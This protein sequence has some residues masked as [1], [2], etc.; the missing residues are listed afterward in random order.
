[1]TLGRHPRR[2]LLRRI[3]LV[4]G[5]L[6][7]LAVLIDLSLDKIRDTTRAS[8][9]PAAALAPRTQSAAPAEGKPSGSRGS[10]L[11]TRKREMARFRF[12][13]ERGVAQARDLDGHVQ[14]AV[15]V[16]DWPAPIAVGD[17]LRRPMR[18]WSLAKPVE[19]VAA[20]QFASRK[21]VQLTAGFTLAMERALRRSENCSARRIVLELEQLA[22]GPAGARVAFA[23]VLR[24]AGA[25]AVVASQREGAAV[26]SAQCAAFLEREGTGLTDRDGEAVLFGTARWTVI[27]A[28]RFARALA[29]GTYGPAGAGVLETMAKPKQLSREPG[30]VFTADL[31]WGAGLAF[32]GYRHAYKAGWG[33]TQWSRRNC[34]PRA[35]ITLAT[36][37]LHEQAGVH[38]PQECPFRF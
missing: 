35:P 34:V 13:L 5:C 27:D 6:A 2:A 11:R 12:A 1:M 25:R 33:G 28:V 26:Q 23:A 9:S 10:V 22:G 36:D 4:A 15:W 20:L 17:D 24:D 18:M 16:D 29:N 8:V 32:R 14:A 7:L 19:A 37:R 21:R 38:N 3:L 30:A 31:L